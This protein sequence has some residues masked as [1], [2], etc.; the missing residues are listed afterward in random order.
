M[1]WT[2]ARRRR[3]VFAAVFVAAL[4]G[5]A[6]FFAHVGPQLA[7]NFSSIIAAFVT[8]ILSGITFFAWLTKRLEGDPTERDRLSAVIAQLAVA[9]QRDLSQ[10]ERYRGVADQVPLMVSWQEASDDLRDHWDNI[11]LA[12]NLDGQFPEILR[13]YRRVPSRR[14]VILG[15]PG[16]GK[17]TLAIHLA[18]RILDANNGSGP[19]PLVFAIG[20]WNPAATDSSLVD[21]MVAAMT[22]DRPGITTAEAHELIPRGS[23]LPILDGLDEIDA[24][25]RAAAVAAI[26]TMPGALVVTCQRAPYAEAT[27][28]A[29][30]VRRAAAI[31]L[32]RITID[33]LTA[34][35]RSGTGSAARTQSWDDV[36]DAIHRHRAPV[37][38]AAFQKPLMVSLARTI[39][40]DGQARVPEEDRRHPI[41]LITTQHFSD[42]DEFESHLLGVFIRTVYPPRSM[43]PYSTRWR[44]RFASRT[45]R[46]WH[47]DRARR[48]LGYLARHAEDSEISWWRL[49]NTV[50]RWARALLFAAVA[51]TVLAGIAQLALDTQFVVVGAALGVGAGAAYGWFFEGEPPRR[52]RLFAAGSTENLRQE[53]VMGLAFGLAVAMLGWFLVS[54]FG[55]FVL[56]IAGGLAGIAPAVIGVLLRK[57]TKPKDLRS[58]IQIA[59][60]GGVTG[61]LIVGLI[62]GV[63]RSPTGSFT[64]WLAVS[65]TLGLAFGLASGPHAPAKVDEA[66]DLN[67]MIRANRAIALY[68]ATMTGLPCALVFGLLTTWPAGIALGIAIGLAMGVV[69]SA[70]GRWIILTRTVLVIGGKLPADLSAFLNDAHRRGVLRQSGAKFAFRHEQLQR[71]LAGGPPPPR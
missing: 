70:W 8:L 38:E 63:N 27:R 21:W 41:D 71:Q 54:R 66:I 1:A 51:A 12:V 37:L 59:A 47:P 61:G 48:W 22:T 50:P 32:D 34:Y 55:W 24:G 49:G 30:V 60:G 58:E 53:I 56:P 25:Q 64:A 42:V 18:R 44:V 45:P 10:D 33:Q 17:T 2:A 46:H 35:L 7:D 14:L 4:A 68:Y 57:D 19:V 26:S 40:T 28:T 29:H 67:H 62:A 16:A 39:Y 31:E 3:I 9:V 20:S 23:I 13:I 69:N 52:L 36:L 43:D 5:L 11:G 6:A 65:L 15:E